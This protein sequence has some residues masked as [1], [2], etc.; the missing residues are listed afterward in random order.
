MELNS[1]SINGGVK[2]SQNQAVTAPGIIVDSEKSPLLPQSHDNNIQVGTS[3]LKGRA[4][5][6]DRNS[7]LQKVVISVSFLAAAAGII[8]FSILL[9]GILNNYTN[10]CFSQFVNDPSSLPACQT[11]YISKKI[12]Y[13]WGIFV[14]S[15]ILGIILQRQWEKPKDSGPQTQKLSKP[16][17]IKR[18]AQNGIASFLN[19]YSY[20]LSFGLGYLRGGLWINDLNSPSE[21]NDYL[22][23]QTVATGIAGSL[24]GMY[25]RSKWVDMRNKQPESTNPDTPDLKPLEKVKRVLNVHRFTAISTVFGLAGIAA[26]TG[27]LIRVNEQAGSIISELGAMLVARPVGHLSAW[28]LARSNSRLSSLDLQGPLIGLS[29]YICFTFFKPSLIPLPATIILGLM[30]GVKDYRYKQFDPESYGEINGVFP[31]K[32]DQLLVRLGKCIKRWGSLLLPAMIATTI[33]SP[34]FLKCYAVNDNI[35]LCPISL[36]I[37]NNIAD[38]NGIEVSIASGIV[39]VSFLIRKIARQQL[40]KNNSEKISK[41]LH[42]WDKYQF[43]MLSLVP[44]AMFRDGYYCFRHQIFENRNGPLL[45]VGLALIGITYGTYSEQLASRRET[46]NLPLIHLLEGPDTPLAITNV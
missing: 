11:P 42:Y 13:E 10:S 29:Y 19:D 33:V 24:L 3:N 23:C 9:D 25:A 5:V 16:E 2:H 7:N 37:S 39:I 38:L 14:S 34:I 18:W 44:Y 1:H 6:I 22:K 21:W 20:E 4:N 40:N 43:D 46:P 8:I 30:H 36:A 41:F 17:K 28:L 12:A 15:I 27:I 45:Y 31:Q 32:D 35:I 26:G